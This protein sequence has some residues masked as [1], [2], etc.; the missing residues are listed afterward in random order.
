MSSGVL[1]QHIRIH[2]GV[3]P[4]SCKLCNLTF[5][6]NGSLTRHMATH[7]EDRPFVCPHSHCNKTFKTSVSCRKHIKI[8]RNEIIAQQYPNSNSDAANPPQEVPAFNEVEE[9]ST[10]QLQ[11]TCTSH[12][13]GTDESYEQAPAH[14]NHSYDDDFSGEFCVVFLYSFF[15]WL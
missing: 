3:R 1:K 14:D 7:T 13:Y 6:T 9:P 11:D 15:R 10:M 12:P 8:H 5:T 4:F 2:E